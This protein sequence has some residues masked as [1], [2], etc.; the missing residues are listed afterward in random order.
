MKTCFIYQPQGIGDII[1]IQKIVHQYKK[2]GYKIVFPLFEYYS[3]IIPYLEQKNI[4]FPLINNDRT[5]KGTF[6]FSDQFYYLMGSTNAVFRK[7]IISEDFIYLSCGPSTTERNHMM[8]G[9]Y[10]AADVD[11][12]NWQDYVKINRNSEKENNLF[13]NILDL[14]DDSVYTL[15]NKSC[16]SHNIDV[17]PVNG[18]TIYMQELEGY[19]VFDWIKVIEKCSRLITVDTSVPILA[20]VY[21]PKHIPCHLINRYYPP[22]FVDLPKIFKLDWQYCL[23][24]N[25]VSI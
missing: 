14:K 10:A 19:S 25:E 5:L 15:I 21:L 20:E 11:Y 12:Q 17:P 8:T 1:F 16:S 2:L 13:Y 6:E 9:K 24:P 7:P 23:Y 3:W 18:K 22:N 4:S